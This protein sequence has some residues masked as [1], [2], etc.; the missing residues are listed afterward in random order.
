MFGCLV[1]VLQIFSRW[2]HE[3]S[4]FTESH[5][6]RSTVNSYIKKHPF[7]NGVRILTVVRLNLLG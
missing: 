6:E 4:S 7:I 2:R 5:D 1:V 3:T